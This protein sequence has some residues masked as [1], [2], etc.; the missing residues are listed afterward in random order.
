MSLSG[1]V[2][3]SS[4][5]KINNKFAFIQNINKKFVQFENSFDLR[6]AMRSGEF[7]LCLILSFV[8]V[9]ALASEVVLNELKGNLIESQREVD[10]EVKNEN[11]NGT[12]GNDEDI[13]AFKRGGGSA[14]RPRPPVYIGGGGGGHRGNGS[15][16]N[17][18]TSISL[19]KLFV[20][21]VLIDKLS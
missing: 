20:V 19:F 17:I 13:D 15:S 4:S 3:N 2:I 1:I 10:F 6:K 16:S 18:L 7:I 8:V 12:K 5:S 11:L 9:K 14:S 21:V